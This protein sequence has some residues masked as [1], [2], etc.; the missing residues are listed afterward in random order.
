MNLVPTRGHLQVVLC[1]SRP[2]GADPYGEDGHDEDDADRGIQVAG[3]RDLGREEGQGGLGLLPCQV[4]QLGADVFEEQ[5]GHR[6]GRGRRG[7][8]GQAQG[9]G[10]RGHQRARAP[11]S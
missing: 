10:Q 3:L 8:V 11:C 7:G 9:R 6:D 4:Q 5:G 1:V 2:E